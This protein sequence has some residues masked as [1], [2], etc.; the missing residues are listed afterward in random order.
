VRT[1]GFPS[2]FSGQG[3]APTRRPSL[4]NPETCSA[5][6]DGLRENPQPSGVKKLRKS[7]NLYRV[8]VGAYRVIYLIKDEAVIVVV[9][10]IGHRREVYEKLLKKYPRDKILEII[11]DDT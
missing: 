2:S 9:V 6:I 11:S 7:E 1:F 5:A 8:R 3:G 10:S 4:S